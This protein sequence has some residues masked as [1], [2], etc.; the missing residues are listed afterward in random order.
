[1]RSETRNTVFDTSHEEGISVVL[2]GIGA[3]GRRLADQLLRRGA[4]I[5]AMVDHDPAYA[6]LTARDLFGDL[7]SGQV[8]VLPSIEHLTHDHQA[9]LAVVAVAD[10]LPDVAPIIL[11]CLSLGL[12]VV[13]TA[14]QMID[15]GIFEPETAR[16]ID[17]QA[18]RYSVSVLGT[19]FGDLYRVN[20]LRL[21]AGPTVEVTGVR[22]RS[23][24][25]PGRDGP[26]ALRTAGVGLTVEEF[27]LFAASQAAGGTPLYEAFLRRAVR[28]M[29][30]KIITVSSDFEGV[31]G[32]AM[33]TR[34]AGG[35]P[36]TAGSRCVTRIETDHGLVVGEADFRLLEDGEE[37]FVEWELEG[38][39]GS[40]VRFSELSSAEGC[41]ASVLRRIPEVLAAAPGLHTVDEFSPLIYT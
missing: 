30:W 12:N 28:S 20:A 25:T 32:P 7:G 34:A 2:I 22:H 10:R 38:L 1:M 23:V 35:E 4:R 39:P 29:G 37:E 27:D 5:A 21:L 13:T 31:Y 9:D 41:M 26:G 19:G 15:P 6:G 17:D 16:A 33:S 3:M 14:G 24:A 11:H 18:K 40:R 36:L 8:R